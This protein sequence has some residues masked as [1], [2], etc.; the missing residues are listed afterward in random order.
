MNK[1]NSAPKNMGKGKKSMRPE[2]G[3]Y[4]A[5]FSRLLKDVMKYYKWHFVIAILGLVVSSAS[6]IAGTYFI[7]IALDDYIVPYI[8]QSNPDLSAFVSAL[9]IMG[10]IYFF[11]VIATYVTNRLMISVGYGTM[12]RYRDDMFKKM[13]RLPIKYFDTHLHGEVMSHYTNDVDT[14]LMLLSQSLLQLLSSA[15]TIVGVFCA[16][17]VLSWQ[18]TLLAVGMLI[19][20]LL[21]TKKIGGGSAKY[22]AK[23]QMIIG[24]VNGYIEEMINGQKVIKVFNHEPETMDGFDKVNDELASVSTKA[25]KYANTLM[26]IMGNLGYVLYVTVAVAGCAMA[27]G[28]VAGITVGTIIAFS[29]YCRNFAQPI[30]Q[31]AMQINAIAVALAGAQ[32]VYEVLDETEEQN[33]GTISLVNTSVDDNGNIIEVNERTGAWAWKQEFEN[34]VDYVPLKGDIRF[35]NVVFSYVEGEEVLHDVSLYAKPGQRIAFVGATGAGKTTITNLINRFYDIKGGSITYDGIDIREINKNDLRKSLA[36][37]LQDTHLFTGSIKENIRYGRLNATDEEVVAAAKLANADFFI[38]HLKDGYDTVITD[39]GE[40]LSQGQRQLL[41][42]ARAAVAN[43]PVLILD[44]ATSSIDTRTEGLI[45]LGMEK[46]MN[47]RTV[48][49]IAHRLSTVKNADAIMVLDDGK[50]IER[51]NHSELLKQRGRYYKLYTGK[52]ELM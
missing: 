8:G 31:V 22:F 26:P 30:S 49:V 28:G 34:K 35:N 29:Q 44:E 46:L 11:G 39:D 10:I 42:I 51:G 2:G 52:F 50:I 47:G 20:M 40:N 48:F 21:V 33:D 45:I 1:T 24:D 4:K 18:L 17:L 38:S 37:V 36:I 25:N 23:Q 41:S 7:K 32:R 3:N 19:I 5:T 13:E 6:S 9:I 43:A 16:M 12:K 15:I 14:I 27:I